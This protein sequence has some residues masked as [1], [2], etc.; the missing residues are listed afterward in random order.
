MIDL[1]E[2]Q[3]KDVHG[4]T[5]ETQQNSRLKVKHQEI[6]QSMLAKKVHMRPCNHW[7]FP[8][9]PALFLATATANRLGT[10]IASRRRTVHHSIK[11]AKRDSTNFTSNIATFFPPTHPDWV[12]RLRRSRHD[13]LIH[14]A[15][16]KKRRHK[17]Q[18]MSRQAQ[19]SIVRFL[20]LH[21]RLN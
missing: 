12:V 18:S 5:A 4:H 17:P 6:F 13:N 2:A 8:D 14:D 20:S 21:G 16:C 19:H 3:N 7:L 1:W 11:A 15:Y 9:N 10:W